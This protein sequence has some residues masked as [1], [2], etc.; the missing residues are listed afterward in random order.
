[1]SYSDKNKIFFGLLHYIFSEQSNVN[2]AF[3]TSLINYTG[4]NES[5]NQ[6]KYKNDSISNDIIKYV[7][8]VKPYHVQFDHYIEKYTPKDDEVKTIISDSIFPE[9]NIRYDSVSV[10]PDIEDYLYTQGTYEIIKKPSEYEWGK[11]KDINFSLTQYYDNER[12]SWEWG[13]AGVIKFDKN[14]NL[15]LIIKHTYGIP[16][17]IYKTIEQPIYEDVEQPIYKTIEQPIYEYYDEDVYEDVEQPI[18]KTITNNIYKTIDQPVYETYFGY[19]EFPKEWGKIIDAKVSTARNESSD[20]W[21]YVISVHFEN[22]TLP[23]LIRNRYANGN[24]ITLNIEYFSSD[25]DSRFN[26]GSWVPSWGKWVNSIAKN[27][28]D[29][30]QWDSIDNRNLDNMAYPTATA[31]GW[32]DGDNFPGSVFT[33]RYSTIVDNDGTLIIKNESG[34]I[35][36]TFQRKEIKT[37]NIL[38]YETVETDEIERVET[39]VTDE[40]IGTEIVHRYVR[41]DT[42]K[43]EVGTENVETNEIIGYRT[44]HQI[45]GSETV[46]TDEIIGYNYDNSDV[47]NLDP[48]FL[49]PNV[50]SDIYNSVSYD[51]DNDIW[52][53]TN[54]IN[55]ENKLLW[56]SNDEI[57]KQISI[58]D[59]SNYDNP[60]WDYGNN[61]SIN[62]DSFYGKISEDGLTL[63]IYNNDILFKTYS[64]LDFTNEIKI[65]PEYKLSFDYSKLENG[66]KYY[67]FNDK[68]I[69]R[70]EIIDENNKK[71]VYDSTPVEGSLYFFKKD[72][73]IKIFENRYVYDYRQNIV[74]MYDLSRK[75][76]ND[77]ENT[78][79]ANRLFLYKTHDLEEIK[80]YLNA[81]FKGMTVKD[82][83][84]DINRFGYDAFLYD[85]K[86]YEEP[87]KTNLFC[88]SKIDYEEYFPVEVGTN[89]IKLN[90]EESLDK[91]DIIIKL[92]N[93]IITD[94]SIDNNIITFDNEIQDTQKINI[95]KFIKKYYYIATTFKTS[96]D[97]G[98]N[99]EFKNVNETENRHFRT[100][101]EKGELIPEKDAPELD[102]YIF[103]LPKSYTNENKIKVYLEKPNGYRTLIKEFIDYNLKNNEV[104][105]PVD[106]IKIGDTSISDKNNWKIYITTIDDAFI[107]DKIYKWEDIYGIAN[108][109]SAWEYYYKNM[110]LIQNLSDTPFLDPY[111][112]ENRPSELTVTY[113]QNSLFIYISKPNKD[114]IDR[115][116]NFDFKNSQSYVN[117]KKYTSLIEDFKPNDREIILSE[118]IFDDPIRDEINNKIIPGKIIINSEMIEY[119]EKIINENNNVILKGLKRGVN[120]TFLNNGLINDEN[121]NI[122]TIPS[123]TNVFAYSKIKEEEYNLAPSYHY[124]KN[125]NQTEFSING[126]I[127]SKKLIEVYKTNNITLLSDIDE[128]SKSFIISDDTIQ[129][130]IY[131]NENKLIKKG[132]LF[133]NNDKIEFET[134]TKNNDNTYTISNFNMINNKKYYFGTEIPSKDFRKLSKNEY[135]IHTEKYDEL[136]DTKNGNNYNYITLTS[137]PKIGECLIIENHNKNV[138]N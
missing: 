58:E 57:I 79:M 72:D 70:L 110:G 114:K 45:V 39:I 19:N 91:D 27:G 13:Y 130:P 12:E 81:H 129:K 134:I 17:P 14:Y 51:K 23:M 49:N 78:T 116:F 89:V 26:S 74:D 33:S 120:G 46:E 106:N 76:K 105:I 108:N 95:F 109:K 85:L 18:Y 2:W 28:D 82:T 22:G 47:H 122:G 65:P 73:S 30:M 35:I 104:I 69:Y 119:N 97:D 101:N 40:I 102:C 87:T 64:L 62:T 71:W 92:D 5:I 103:N 88:L 29:L 80:D 61:I 48:I 113:P 59:A 131:D 50:S 115:I 4:I 1:M 112:S 20:G 11:F 41:T 125:Y 136:K 111:Y 96:S 8:N 137:K 15:P 98:F 55:S 31:W 93:T 128:N 127:Q 126:H 67:D 53:L 75:Q 84:F 66:T 44:E 94:F 52:I 10:K 133:I 60:K 34:V 43:R 86:L 123:G 21:V 100:Y 25:V 37:D 7:K 24:E 16:T 99:K 54:A 90:Y 118:D 132:Y 83:N 135:T 6:R 107:Y 138:F 121:E 32:D 63:E 38:R 77:F 3:K 9:I 42:I 56:T 68:I 36:R 117:I 124:I